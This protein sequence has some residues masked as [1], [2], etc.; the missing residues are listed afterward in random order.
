MR[1]WPAMDLGRSGD[2]LDVAPGE[3]TGAGK[4]LDLDDLAIPDCEAEGDARATAGEP[5]TARDAVDKCDLRHHGAAVE[6]RLAE[7]YW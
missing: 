1:A 5:D 7:P 3:M 6:I 4:E 2:E